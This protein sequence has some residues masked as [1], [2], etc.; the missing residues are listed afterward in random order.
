MSEEEDPFERKPF[1][2]GKGFL[3]YPESWELTNGK[4]TN[5]D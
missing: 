4:L 2:E 3:L 1:W 5:D